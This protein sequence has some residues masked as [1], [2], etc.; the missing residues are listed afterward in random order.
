[1][2]GQGGRNW[3]PMVPARS[4]RPLPCRARRAGGEREFERTHPHPPTTPGAAAALGGPQPHH[5]REDPS[6]PTRA[7]QQL[8]QPL[9]R[10]AGMAPG[11]TGRLPGGRGT[12]SV[13]G[14]R[15]E[16]PLGRH[17]PQL[18]GKD[19]SESWERGPGPSRR[20]LRPEP[21]NPAVRALRPAGRCG[22]GRGRRNARAGPEEAGPRR[23]AHGEG[24]VSHRKWAWPA[25]SK[26]RVP[27][28]PASLRVGFPF[29]EQLRQT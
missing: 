21:P 10:G 25:R 5:P 28:T 23:L 29:G 8:L 4:H 27:G 19:S 1:M 12:R 14:A 20:P 3:P 9:E 15:P 18:R 2:R 13:P 6:L 22:A 11:P 16:L 7:A 17:G 26:G 24:R